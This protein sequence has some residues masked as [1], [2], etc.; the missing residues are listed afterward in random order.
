M[1]KGR[2]RQISGRGDAQLE[3]G[4]GYRSELV[5]NNLAR[6]GCGSLGKASRKALNDDATHE[7]LVSQPEL[8]DRTYRVVT[9][10]G[11]HGVADY[12]KDVAAC[13]D[14]PS[15]EDVGESPSN[16][17][18][19]AGGQQPARADPTLEGRCVEVGSYL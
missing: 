17:K 14:D 13:D 2:A 11:A 6:G 9:S 19:H 7:D 12:C 16:N 1:S 10:Y 5:G 15:A 18:C 8:Q 3:E 4:Y